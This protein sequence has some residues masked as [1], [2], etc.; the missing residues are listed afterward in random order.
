MVVASTR[1]EGQWLLF[2]VLAK[3]TSDNVDFSM[4]RLNIIEKNA[5][6]LYFSRMDLQDKVFVKVK[7]IDHIFEKPCESDCF[8]KNR[9]IRK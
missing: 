7:E 1:V 9:I 3:E 6:I 2:G 5:E 8:V 4:Q